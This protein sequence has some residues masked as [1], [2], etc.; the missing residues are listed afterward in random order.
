MKALTNI[1]F[2]IFPVVLSACTGGSES[3]LNAA[4][5]EAVARGRLVWEAEECAACHGDDGRGTVIG[6]SLEQV[7]NQWNADE[8]VRFLQ[9][10]G[11]YLASNARLAELTT[12]FDVDMPGVQNASQEQTSDLAAFLMRG[13]W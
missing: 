10:P 6:P 12:R 5:L 13:G 7:K 9:D 4:E 2:L 3:R 1:A 11:P 8:L